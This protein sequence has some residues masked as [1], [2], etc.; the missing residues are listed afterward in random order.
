MGDAEKT[1][2]SLA[3]NAEIPEHSTV[4]VNF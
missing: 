4:N 2:R 1:E 3:V